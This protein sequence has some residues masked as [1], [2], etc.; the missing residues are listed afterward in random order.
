MSAY[1]TCCF[2]IGIVERQRKGVSEPLGILFA[3]WRW[4]AVDE[5]FFPTRIM[6]VN[7]KMDV[8]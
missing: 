2:V 5:S 1:L 6:A 3:R 8:T 7:V 4:E